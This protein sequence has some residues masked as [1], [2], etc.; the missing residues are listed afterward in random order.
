MSRRNKV[1]PE[2]KIRIV[3]ACLDG[4]LSQVEAE[5]QLGV[6]RRVVADWIRL[7]TSE[8]VSAFLPREHK[9][10]YDTGTKEA[11]AKAYLAGEGSQREICKRFKIRSTG[12]LRSWIKVYNG[13]K[14]F[15]KAGGGSHMTKA[16][17][18]TQ[19]E[20]IKIAKEC[21]AS[22]RNYRELA[23]KYNVSYQQVYSWTNKY[24]DQ[25]ELGLE[26]RRGQ[27]T[28]QQKPRTAEE[29]LKVRIAQ[30][31][32]ENYML[33]MERDLLKKLDEIERRRG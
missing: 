12:Q 30:L 20:R 33:K 19:E 6:A 18:T 1:S 22:G 32:H 14:D 3:K 13:Q 4:K 21:I 29:E 16:R 11:A 15:K 27:R 9:Q 17:K 7:Y 23:D 28:A 5:A 31:E 25:G 24:A 8:G 2:E 10:H 26:D